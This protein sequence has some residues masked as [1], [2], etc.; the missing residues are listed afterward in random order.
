MLMGPFESLQWEFADTQGA[1]DATAAIGVD[2]TRLP[3][4]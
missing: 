3:E 4:A 2:H 1:R